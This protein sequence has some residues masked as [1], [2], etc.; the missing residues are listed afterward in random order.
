MNIRAK[1]SFGQHFLTDQHVVRKIVEAA[2]I[3]PRQWILEI[4][5]GTGVLTRA[6][7][8]AGA[9]VAAVEADHDLIHPLR[10]QF[11]NKIILFEG[12][13]LG[14][15]GKAAEKFLQDQKMPFQVVANI[16]YNITSPI[17]EHFFR[18]TPYPFR[19]VLMVQ[20]EVADRMLAT[21]PDMS[22]LSVVIQ[23][24]ATG[25]KVVKVSSGA[26]RPSPKVDSMVV[27]LDR[28]ST[29]IKG[30]NPENVIAVAKAGFHARRKQLHRNIA[31]A[32]FCSS[33]E[34]KQILFRL[35]KDSRS[36]AENLTVEDWA[37]LTSLLVNRK[38]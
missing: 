26:F 16:P 15:A 29:W 7:V 2:E 23:L 8:D 12:D 6:L 35:G 18:E 19:L 22:L 27:R 36:R 3:V 11:E 30:I 5:P 21:P 13:I 17:L 37:E 38:K 1:K 10:E 31:E 28:R 25:K 34:M 20:K 14:S 24:Y 9:N 32:G 4:G 33:E